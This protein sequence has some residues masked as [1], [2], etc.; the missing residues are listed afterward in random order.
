MRRVKPPPS[1]T[2]NRPHSQR[3]FAPLCA[4]ERGI[5]A[6]GRWI[7]AIAMRGT[8][9]A[10]LRLLLL[11]AAALI[12]AGAAAAETA[13]SATAEA[14]LPATIVVLD[15]SSSMNTKIGGTSKIASVR[16]E[17]GQALGSLRRSSVVRAR[18]LR[19]SQGRQLRR[20]RDLGEAR[21]VYLRVEE[22]ASRQHQAEGPSPGRGGPQRRRQVR[23]AAR[24]VRH[25]ADR[26]RRR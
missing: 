3:I 12:G 19:P 7:G 11:P 17:L 14:G 6:C 24:Q 26:R 13:P 18:C 8:R 23:A 15:A 22:Q 25:R 21:R 4:P 20:Q 2:P 5:T 10:G 9:C 1:D 16:T